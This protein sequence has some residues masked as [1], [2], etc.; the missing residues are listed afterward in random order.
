MTCVSVRFVALIAAV[1]AVACAAVDDKA[2]AA[3]PKA[4]REYRTG[5][6]I[7]VKDPR[8]TTDDERARAAEQLRQMQ[9]GGA[10]VRP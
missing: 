7:P 9:Q 10:A 2:S 4:Q 1:L 8:P 3:E 5:S 6:N